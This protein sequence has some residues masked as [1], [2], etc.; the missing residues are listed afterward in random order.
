[1]RLKRWNRG[2]NARLRCHPALPRMRAVTDRMAEARAMIE[3][4][5]QR[6]VAR[7]KGL[8]REYYLTKDEHAKREFEDANA[9]FPFL[10]SRAWKELKGERPG[11]PAPAS[12]P[13]PAPTP[14]LPVA[15]N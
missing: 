10:F 7:I 6:E 9:Q 14:A 11:T 4:R 12:V 1:M 8:L 5:E 3:Q 13:V 15:G 2:I